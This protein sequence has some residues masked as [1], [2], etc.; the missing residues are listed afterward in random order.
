MSLGDF[1]TTRNKNS[2]Q[3]GIF[4]TETPETTLPTAKTEQKNTAKNKPPSKSAKG[5]Q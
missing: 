1:F 4:P 5:N 3:S 2:H